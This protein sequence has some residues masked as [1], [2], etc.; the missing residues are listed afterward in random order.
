LAARIF[1]GRLATLPLADFTDGELQAAARRAF[2]DAEQFLIVAA[3]QAKL[4]TAMERE[5]PVRS[6]SD[7]DA[8]S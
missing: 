1:V 3:E 7:D 8:R 2:G 6:E 4:P 5:N